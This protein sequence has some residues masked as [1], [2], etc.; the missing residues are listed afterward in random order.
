MH[1]THT[2]QELPTYITTD[3]HLENV[4]SYKYL[5]DHSVADLTWNNYTGH[6][7]KNDKQLV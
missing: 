5:S 4:L 7:T 6:V 3:S 1:V 2:T